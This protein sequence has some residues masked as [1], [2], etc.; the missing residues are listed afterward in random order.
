MMCNKE[1]HERT[2][3]VMVSRVFGPGF[4]SYEYEG[5]WSGILQ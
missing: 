5:T 1:I 4:L 2:A 3:T